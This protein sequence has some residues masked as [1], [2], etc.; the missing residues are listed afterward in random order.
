M[1]AMAEGQVFPLLHHNLTERE[2][3][4]LLIKKR[5]C[6]KTGIKKLTEVEVVWLIA[7]DRYRILKKNV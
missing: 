5:V 3:I 1:C 4:E 6:G 7:A 2:K